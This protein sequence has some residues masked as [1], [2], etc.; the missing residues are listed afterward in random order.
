MFIV[1]NVAMV[2]YCFLSIDR[3]RTVIQSLAHINEKYADTYDLCFVNGSVQNNGSIPE[4]FACENFGIRLLD[5]LGDKIQS[6]SW[7]LK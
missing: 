4:R 2:V 5:G 7:L 1:Q 3:D 6:S